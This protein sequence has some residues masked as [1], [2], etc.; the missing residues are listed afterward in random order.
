MDGV[1]GC[2][3][4]EFPCACYAGRLRDRI[5]HPARIGALALFLIG[6]F[7]IQAQNA[8]GPLPVL[9]T[10]RQAHI[11]SNS[12]AERHY[13]VQLDRAQITFIVAGYAFLQDGTDG[14]FALTAP[15]SQAPRAGDLVRVTGVT[16]PGDL[17]TMIEGAQFKIL[18]HAPLPPAP[19]VSID[20]LTTGAWDSRLVTLEG[21]IRSLTAI[22]GVTR[23]SSDSVPQECAAVIASGQDEVGIVVVRAED[24]DRRNLVDAKVRLKVV[25]AGN[26]NQRKQLIGIRA[27]TQDFSS[28]RVEERPPADPWK[29][30]LTDTAG[31]MRLGQGDPGHRVR[32]R[33]V[34]TSTWGQQQF[35]LMDSSHGIFVRTEAPVQLRVGEE[36]DVA[37]FPSWGGYTSVL[38][39]ASFRRD[40][41]G[42]APQ[43]VRLTAGEALKGEHDAEP[44]EIDGQLLYRSRTPSE[45]DLLLTDGGITFQAA[46][47]ADAP[48]GFPAA[49]KP[50]SRLRVTG[51]CMIE[52]NADKTPRALK[53]LL[54]SPAGVVVLERPSWWTAQKTLILAGI[55]F[56]VVTVIAAWNVILRRRV[57]GQTRLI[58]EQ[59]EEAEQLRMQAEAAHEEKSASLAS[60]L[61][62]QNELLAAQEK[63]RYQATHDVLTGV[64]NRGALL[65]LLRSE[66]ERCLRTH[67]SVGV[68]MLDVDHFKPVNDTHG[69]LVGDGVLKE[70]AQRI[71]RAIRGYDMAGRYGGE[72][73]LVILP[74]CNREEAESS[75]ERIRAAICSVP[76][77]VS[78][79][80]IMLTVS[81]GATVAGEAEQSETEILSIADL[82]LYEAKSAG[83]N[84][85]VL[86]TLFDQQG[87][88]RA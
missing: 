71:S 56:A 79:C 84:C 34:V 87:V 22:A 81:I 10:A 13:P 2:S 66:M 54:Q 51:I 45:E 63:L 25:A 60:V 68:L 62:L 73:F 70:V 47:P 11:L 4:R 32:V 12:E 18:G 15:M 14:I 76:F 29:L 36:L 53:I 17:L 16:A 28:L 64:W 1:G 58:R 27:F 35:S 41:S 44:V 7:A 50:G 75:A 86:R 39:N 26:F 69:H 72:E 42:R 23:R 46:L 43:P 52:V 31:V 19:L 55:L 85:I 40:G 77:F 59:L 9:R 33:G 88:G 6:T 20:R 61:T 8:S 74:G 5:A 57:R 3:D 21:T 30:P 83:R 80:G 49:L 65:D 78:G 38:E 48:Q 24:C 37:G 67:S 82:A